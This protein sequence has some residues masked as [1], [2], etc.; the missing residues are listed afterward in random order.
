MFM[1]NLISKEGKNQELLNQI[2]KMKEVD[3]EIKQKILQIIVDRHN[4]LFRSKQD[5]DVKNIVSIICREIRNAM[6]KNMRIFCSNLLTRIEG[7]TE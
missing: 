7:L 6:N 2:C 4:S 3:V 5:T 1:I